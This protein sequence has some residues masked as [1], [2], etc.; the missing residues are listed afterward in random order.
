MGGSYMMDSLMDDLYNRATEILRELEEEGGRMMSYI[1]SG[2][3]K[4][5]I[6]EYAAKKQGIIDLGRN[7]VAGVKTDTETRG[8]R[9]RRKPLG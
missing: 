2:R 3:S 1:K 8:G 6:E 4:I 7:I 9:T 5:R